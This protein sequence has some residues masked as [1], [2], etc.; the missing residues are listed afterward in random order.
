MRLSGDPSAAYLRALDASPSEYAQL[1]RPMRI[2]LPAKPFFAACRFAPAPFLLVAPSTVWSERRHT[3]GEPTFVLRPSR[4]E[5]AGVL[6]HANPDR[7]K[8]RRCASNANSAAETA[9]AATTTTTVSFIGELALIR[10]DGHNWRRLLI[11]PPEEGKQTRGVQ[12]A[13]ANCLAGGRL[14]DQQAIVVAEGVSRRQVNARAKLGARL[15]SRRAALA[16][17]GAG[18]HESALMRRTNLIAQV[19]KVRHLTKQSGWPNWLSG[20]RVARH[21][22]G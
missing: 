17:A 7:R 12:V 14:I 21:A 3:Q 9:A 13:R 6:F 5:R 8:T 22:P 20:A 10:A 16:L 15:V 2:T 19:E 4:P 11:W 18:A 1:S